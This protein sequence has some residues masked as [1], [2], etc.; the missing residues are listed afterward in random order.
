LGNLSIGEGET[1]GGRK[2]NLKEVKWM[3]VRKFGIKANSREELTQPYPAAASRRARGSL[4]E[5]WE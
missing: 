3:L 4:Q 1:T 5:A 2:K